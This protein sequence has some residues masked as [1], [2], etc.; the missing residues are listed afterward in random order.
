MEIVNLD[1]GNKP[2]SAT[3]SIYKKE[4]KS[5]LSKFDRFYRI[6]KYESD[7][8]LCDGF[9][10]H[11]SHL[12]VNPTE[13]MLIKDYVSEGDS[14]ATV[15]GSGDFAFEAVHKGA[16]EV[17]TFDINRLQ[18]YMA[19]L[20]TLA[21]T[22]LTR[23][24]YLKFFTKVE[25]DDFLSYRLYEKI[26]KHPL[27][28]KSA[29]F[30]FWDDLF[31]ELEESRRLFKKNEMYQKLMYIK[32][33]RQSGEF[34]FMSALFGT[35]FSTDYL[36][37]D[38][39]FNNMAEQVGAKPSKFL[40]MLHGEQGKAEEGTYL[41]SDES[42]G[43]LQSSKTKVFYASGDIIKFN[44]LLDK[45]KY[46]SNPNFRGFN[47]IYL[48]NIPQYIGEDLFTKTVSEQLIPNLVD[49]GS[50]LYCCQGI[51]LTNLSDTEI[52]RMVND[53]KK[54]LSLMDS[55][56]IEYITIVQSLVSLLSYK[57]L[58]ERYNVEII[59]HESYGGSY[60]NTSIDSYVK[61]KKA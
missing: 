53:Y 34:D 20:K 8:S 52:D 47:L 4:V 12:Y 61:I 11:G 9:Y 31:F 39:V 30:S 26:R 40:S 49:G 57:Q 25:S 43:K 36:I 19:S 18:Y 46:L 23:E 21:L 45:N 17:F 58:R 35:L 2:L 59:G 10:L 24:E 50:I 28:S 51:N 29:I 16:S 22:S 14:V 56:S 3:K 42:Y 48:S 32:K 33:L 44:L 60:N 7:K 6:D 38:S 55:Q 37:C 1:N 13:Y 5:I 15:L 27:S 54:E 41:S